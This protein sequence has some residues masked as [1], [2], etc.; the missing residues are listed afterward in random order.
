MHANSKRTIHSKITFPTN[1]RQR[2]C[3]KFSA[4]FAVPGKG[5]D[6]VQTDS[7]QKSNIVSRLKNESSL[8]EHK[9]F[10]HQENVALKCTICDKMVKN[11]R[12]GH[13]MRRAHGERCHQCLLCDK[14]FKTAKN[15]KVH[16]S[17]RIFTLYFVFHSI[18]HVGTHSHSYRRIFVR[19]LIL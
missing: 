17:F 6:I 8:R 12:L 16:S 4:I 13:H 1:I 5:S 18:S 14:A 15:L 2:R 9:K 19:L 11:R 7:M 3:P 10:Q